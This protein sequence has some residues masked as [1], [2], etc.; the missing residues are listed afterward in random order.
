MLAAPQIL[1]PHQLSRFFRFLHPPSPSASLSCSRELQKPRRD[2]E[3]RCHV[4][5][6]EHAN[7]TPGRGQQHCTMDLSTVKQTLARLAHM[8]KSQ[9]LLVA[10]TF[11][12]S[13]W[14]FLPGVQDGVYSRIY[15]EAPDEPIPTEAPPLDHPIGYLIQGAKM[16]LDNV[17]SKETTN[18]SAAAQAYRDR[19]GRQPPPGF[20]RWFSFAQEH[21]ALIIEDFF[22]RIYDDLNPF[23]GISAK[24]IREPANA[25]LH[26]ISVRNG[27]TTM[28]SDGRE[29]PWMNLWKD[30]ISSISH[31]L[32]DVDLPMNVMDESRVIVPWEKV[33]QYIKIE[34]ENRRLVP[35]TDLVDE[36]QSL[37]F[38]DP[39]KTSGPQFDGIGWYWFKVAAGCPP[40][41]EARTADVTEIEDF[42]TRPPLT[43][44]R[45]H[46]SYEGYVQNWTFA[47]SPCE[48]AHYRSVHGTFVEPVSQSTTKELFPMFGGSKLSVNND[49]LLPPAMYWAEGT[50]YSS[51][52]YHGPG[53]EKKEDTMAWRGGA[54]GGRN[55][56]NNWTR[57]QRHRFVSMV[58][59]TKVRE[60]EMHPSSALNFILPSDGAYKLSTRPPTSNPQKMGDWVDSWSDVAFTGLNCFPMEPGK[61]NRKKCSYTGPYFEIAKKISMHDQFA[62]KYLPDID[63]NSFSGRYRAFLASTSVPIKATVYDEW[64]DS[65]LVPWKHF[66]PMDNTFAD[67]YGIMEYFVGSETVPGHD[68]VAQQIA[69]EGKAWARRVLRKEDM[70]IYVF[71]LLLEYARL[72][73]D[74]RDV[75]GW[76]E[77]AETKG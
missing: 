18:I 6:C 37:G 20:D 51:K 48:N 30:L 10:I 8:R 13:V 2:V 69:L 16:E 65:R 40:N 43:G 26:K 23:W 59:G 46:K 9:Y 45:P 38:L 34:R 24:D 56:K 63:G 73:D 33:D 54:T 12:G 55:S 68:V 1:L 64:H 61:H 49:I 44:E 19:R 4:A 58:N 72:C 76:K 31:E 41:S 57:F 42:S 7:L 39:D 28:R 77:N 75:L 25:F 17:M 62:S 32:P 14:F 22:D 71:R 47:K 21:E 27:K 15:P 70:Q 74:R 36:S 50:A 35:E 66:V 52:N 3:H 5:I 67:I 29:R 53:W 60:A 11:I